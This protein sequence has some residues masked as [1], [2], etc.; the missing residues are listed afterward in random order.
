[1]GEVKKWLSKIMP[2][3]LEY[4]SFFLTHK[5]SV[6]NEADSL[7]DCGIDRDTKVYVTLLLKFQEIEPEPAIEVLSPKPYHPLEE[8]SYPLKPQEGYGTQP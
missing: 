3:S 7:S 5:G 2:K 6:L 8:M 4:E 1:M